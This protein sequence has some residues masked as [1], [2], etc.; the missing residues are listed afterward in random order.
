MTNNFNSELKLQQNFLT[1]RYNWQYQASIAL[2]QKNLREILSGL[3][4]VLNSYLQP[5]SIIKNLKGRDRL[6]IINTDLN[7]PFEHELLA[8]DFNWNPKDFGIERDEAVSEISSSFF[9]LS[10]FDHFA[11]NEIFHKVNQTIVGEA[12]PDIS[13]SLLLSDSRLKLKS[14]RLGVD[15]FSQSSFANWFVSTPVVL[16]S[17]I[18]ETT[19][20]EI[21]LKVQSDGH[22]SKNEGLYNY[23]DLITKLLA[24]VRSLFD[25]DLESDIRS[26]L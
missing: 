14:L 16:E 20:A 12:P 25:V 15:T 9:L 24:Q 7:L 21:A 17:I 2:E 1:R 11:G 3:S 13:L 22:K 4:S 19:V 6:N 10:P 8:C 26:K 5:D 23:T 18:I